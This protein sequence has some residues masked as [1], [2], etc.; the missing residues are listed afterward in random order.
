LINVWGTRQSA[1]LQNWTTAIKVGALVI[2]S[3]A[4]L[5]MGRGYEASSAA[6]WPASVERSI[7]TGFGLAM[8]G[9]LWAYEGWQYATY[10]AGETLDPQ[11]NFPRAFLLGTGVLITVYLLANVAYLAALGPTPASKTD[12][13]AATSV[14]LVMGP[15]AAKLVALAILV[16]IF[17]AANSTLLTAPRVFYAMASDGLFFRRL[18]EVH[19]RFGTPA[20]SIIASSIWAALLAATGTFDQLLTYVVFIGWIFYALAA[21]CVFVYRMRAPEQ[22]IPYRVPGYPFTPLLFIIAAAALVANTIAAKPLDALVGLGIVM[23]GA[24]A[25]MVWRAGGRNRDA[26]A[27]TKLAATNPGRAGEA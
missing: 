17:S 9:V 20:F 21:A 19:P 7:V 2:M 26:A 8:L 27:A 1:D 11:R 18:A 4:L 10:S 6:M 5:W 15:A 14:A 24:P 16:S 13:I 3:A 22:H 12:S 23:V 25:Y